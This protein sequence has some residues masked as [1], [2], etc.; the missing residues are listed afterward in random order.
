MDL[1]ERDRRPRLVDEP[2]AELHRP[3]EKRIIRDHEV[4]DP[5]RPRFTRLERG[6]R[7]T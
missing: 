6:A 1:V 3:F 4:G 5:N 7:R 2:L